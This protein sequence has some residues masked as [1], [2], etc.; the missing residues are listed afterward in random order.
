VLFGRRVTFAIIVLAS[1]LLLIALAVTWL[2]QML[3]IAR[4]GSVYFIEDNPAILVT[5][6]VLAAV[7]SIFAAVVFVLQL[8]KLGEK[9]RGDERRA[10]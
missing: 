2:I 3:V 9:R 1:Q 8:K 6:I 7:I 4:N 10:L 5:E